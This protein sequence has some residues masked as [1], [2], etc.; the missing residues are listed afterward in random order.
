MNRIPLRDNEIWMFCNTLNAR[1]G[2]V[3][4][5][6][7]EM[8]RILLQAQDL[9]TRLWEMQRTTINPRKQSL[10]ARESRSA[11]ST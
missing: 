11:T 9:I 4:Y 8:R 2:A 10:D 1:A 7:K 6:D 5:S 3:I